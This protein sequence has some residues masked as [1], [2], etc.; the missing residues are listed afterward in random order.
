MYKPELPGWLTLTPFTNYQP[1]RRPSA[2]QRCVT[3]SWRGTRTTATTRGHRRR[4][5]TTT[6]KMKSRCW[7]CSWWTTCRTRRPA[8]TV[9]SISTLQHL[10]VSTIKSVFFY[11]CCQRTLKLDVIVDGFLFTWLF[12]PTDRWPKKLRVHCVVLKMN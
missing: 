4:M 9:G 11:Y 12:A 5:G 7:K 2:D 3:L 8:A 10:Q 6:R 1:W